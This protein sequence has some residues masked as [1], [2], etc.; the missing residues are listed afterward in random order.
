M[1]LLK[2][3]RTPFRYTFFNAT[4]FIIGL[5]LLVFLL[6]NILGKLGNYLALNVILV[7]EY[8]MYWQ[9][10]TYMFVH[11]DFSHLFST[12]WDF[13]SLAWQ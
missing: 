1:N 2:R 11:G 9:F 12:C 10:L 13:F 7:H 3:I 5:N 6:T 4:F 8:K